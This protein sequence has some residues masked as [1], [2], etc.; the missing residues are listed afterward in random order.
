[1]KGYNYYYDCNYQSGV[2]YGCLLPA[3]MHKIKMRSILFEC[4]SVDIVS[5][6]ARSVYFNW[7]RR[8]QIIGDCLCLSF[9]LQFGNWNECKNTIGRWILELADPILRNK[10][11][12]NRKKA[13]DFW[14]FF[15]LLFQK[16][17]SILEQIFIHKHEQHDS[18]ISNTGE[19][20]SQVN[21]NH[22]HANQ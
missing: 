14:H 1:M 6:F 22:L 2:C 19:N 10:W 7:Q 20:S 12:L 18:K 15:I 8:T 5:P 11:N 4:I 16:Q 13:H 17:D 3:A 9:S 21:L